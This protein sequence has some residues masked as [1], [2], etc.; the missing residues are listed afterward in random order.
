MARQLSRA[1]ASWVHPQQHGFT[2]G[3]DTVDALLSLETCVFSMCRLYPYSSAVFADLAQAFASLSRPWV[4]CCAEASG[5]PGPLLWY[6]RQHL[7]AGYSWIRWRRV[8]HAGFQLTSGVR[9]GDPLSGVLFLLAV[10]GW[11]RFSVI[12]W[13]R[14]IHLI[15][16]A[17]DLTMVVR[18]L[19][20][21]S[22]CATAV[23]MLEAVAGLRLN[24]EKTK[25]LPI[26]SATMDEFVAAFSTSLTRDWQQVS[27]VDSLRYLGYLVG[28]GEI[29]MDIYAVQKIQAR[30]HAIPTLQLGSAA[31]AY[32][33]NV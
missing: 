19:G 8:T 24:F 28:R 27:V 15:M 23:A 17:D 4:L 7:Q 3:R 26:G 29:E 12:R 21:L 22:A 25:V 31:N 14:D 13:G 18:S 20:L 2:Q 30:A 9:Q 33:G 11:L 16:F 1:S 32:L 10:D 5:C 6:L